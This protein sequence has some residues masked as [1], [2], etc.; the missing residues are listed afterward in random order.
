MSCFLWRMEEKKQE[1]F[2]RCAGYQGMDI[3]V[4]CGGLV[5]GIMKVS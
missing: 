1:S 4:Y 5:R 2:E 3:F